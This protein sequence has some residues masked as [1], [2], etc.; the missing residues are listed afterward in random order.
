MG[1]VVPFRVRE[2]TKTFESNFTE[3]LTDFAHLRERELIMEE[4]G[5][6]RLN[7]KLVDLFEARIG[8]FIVKHNLLNPELFRCGLYVSHLLGGALSREAGSLYVSDYLINGIGDCDPAALRHGG[9]LYCVLCILFDGRGRWRA[10]RE[11]DYMK[12]GMH[13]YSLYFAVT[14]RRI[15]LS[16]SRNF[17][18][19]VRIT[20]DCVSEI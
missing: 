2:K 8:S 11:G 10:M 16:M 4:N 5:V 19:I 20:R 18:A 6:C 7:G 1:R 15:G 3:L 12:L 14:G 13:L 9:D 17:E